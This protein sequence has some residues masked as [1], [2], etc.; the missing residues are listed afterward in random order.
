MINAMSI[1]VEEYFQV[2]AFSDV[3]KQSQWDSFESRVE[4]SI[5]KALQLFDDANVKATFFAL[6]WIA[7]RHPGMIREIAESGHEIAS[8]GYAHQK[9]TD[10][11]IEEFKAD[12]L[13]AKKMLED[14][15]GVEVRGYRAPSFSIGAENLDAL[16]VLAESGHVYS[17]SIYPVSH[18]HYGMP[19]C[20]RFACNLRDSQLLEL[21]MTTV[22]LFGKNLPCSGGGFFRLLPYRYYRWA[23]Q[24]VNRTDRQPAIFYLHPWELDPG[25]PRMKNIRFKSG[26]RHYLNLDK[27]ETR[28]ARLLADFRWDRMDR[29][30]LGP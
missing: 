17:S 6:G 16:D 27:T 28:L 30:F 15:T 23:I 19:H 3:S 14:T 21:P 1:D 13:R 24:R 12:V 4:R 18:D 29:V 2:W 9:V 5:A 11:T 7:R 8:H 22:R 10:Q 25:Q 26:L 20:P